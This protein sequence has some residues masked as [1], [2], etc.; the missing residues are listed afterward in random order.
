MNLSEISPTILVLA[1]AAIVILL[2]RLGYG[3]ALRRSYAIA[4]SGQELRSTPGYYGWYAL[5]WMFLPV[6]ALSLVVA[7]LGLTET[8]DVPGLWVAAA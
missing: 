4:E 7:T 8:L 5:L 3:M 1:T 6:L 2:G